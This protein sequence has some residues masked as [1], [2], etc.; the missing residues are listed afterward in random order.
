MSDFPK[1]KAAVVQ[2]G[3]VL[4]DCRASLEKACRL[5]CE[6]AAE[7][8]RLILFPEAFIPAYPRGLSFGTV[9]GSRSAQGRDTWL[10]Y[11]ANSITVPGA[12]VEALGEAARQANAALVVGVIE[13]D[14]ELSRGTLY[15]TM[16]YFAPDG[17]L[18]GKH[19][20]LKPTAAER[21]VWGEGDG[22]T[23][24]VVQT[25]FGKIGGLICWENYMPL[26]R[27][28]IYGKGVEIYLAP[29]AEFA[30]DMAG[31]AAP[32]RLRGALFCARLQSICDKGDVPG[33]AAWR[34]RPG[35]PA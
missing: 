14:S 23:L 18:I 16:L 15:C 4:F 27:M 35:K 9:V 22:S 7:G 12:E 11:W 5:T 28:A 29:T 6:A 1:V 13:R 32:H 21:L 2:A 20:K 33:R 34:R 31:D 26:A 24:T 8:A 30:R 19:R 10:R 3:S 25:E 17:R